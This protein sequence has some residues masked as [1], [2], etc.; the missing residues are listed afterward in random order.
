MKTFQIYFTGNA[1][2]ESRVTVIIYSVGLIKIEKN[3]TSHRRLKRVILTSAV[4]SYLPLWK[5]A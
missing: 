4:S 5:S 1:E 2:C 3:P